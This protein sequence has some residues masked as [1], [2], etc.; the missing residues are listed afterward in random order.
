MELALRRGTRI[1]GRVVDRSGEPVESTVSVF[2][3]GRLLARAPSDSSG[4]FEID[5]LPPVRGARLECRVP[6]RASDEAAGAGSLEGVD[7]GTDREDLVVRVDDSCRA[8]LTVLVPQDGRERPRIPR[9]AR[10]WLAPLRRVDPPG[11]EREGRWTEDGG[12]VRFDRLPAGTYRASTRLGD[13]ARVVTLVAG[14]SRVCELEP[15]DRLRGEDP[16]WITLRVVDP[17]GR[18]IPDASLRIEP[19]GRILGPDECPWLA[20]RSGVFELEVA[21]GRPTTLIARSG[22]LVGRVQVEVERRAHRAIGPLLLEE[23]AGLQE[24]R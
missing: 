24:S 2:W 6:G 20:D 7:L 22:P 5:A 19:R 13:L 9:S 3:A 11:F 17:E 16:A 14:E 12:G 18:P 21:G 1:E 23:P 10:A 4:R 15:S 8:N